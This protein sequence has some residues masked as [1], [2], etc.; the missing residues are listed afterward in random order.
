MKWTER[1]W[2]I[3]VLVRVGVNGAFTNLV[4]IGFDALGGT[5]NTGGHFRDFSFFVFFFL[6]TIQD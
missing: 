5:C 1:P 3:V 4:L 6:Y 2:S